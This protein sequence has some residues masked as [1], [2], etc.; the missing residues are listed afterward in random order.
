METPAPSD[1]DTPTK[2]KP[3]KAPSITRQRTMSTRSTVLQVTSQ[4]ELHGDDMDEDGDVP[5]EVNVEMSNQ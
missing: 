2:K 4:Q 1:P 3:R 5:I